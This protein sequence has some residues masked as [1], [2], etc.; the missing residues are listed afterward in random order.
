MTIRDVDEMK[1]TQAET[2][3]QQGERDNGM[4]EA[5][6]EVEIK[7]GENG[8]DTGRQPVVALEG[9]WDDCRLNSTSSSWSVCAICYI[10]LK[11]QLR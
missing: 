8:K 10:G 7:A 6:V 5:V 1:D 4:A 11:A 3:R 2:E 9:V